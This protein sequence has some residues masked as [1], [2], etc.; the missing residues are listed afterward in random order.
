MKNEFEK[1]LKKVR[2]AQFKDRVSK[3]NTI[4]VAVKNGWVRVKFNLLKP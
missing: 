3:F 2:I 4:P 1:R